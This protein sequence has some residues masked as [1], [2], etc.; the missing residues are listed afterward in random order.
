MMHDDASPITAPHGSTA[1]IGMTSTTS[2]K[3]GCVS[4]SEHHPHHDGL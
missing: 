4:G 3:I 1:V 2:L